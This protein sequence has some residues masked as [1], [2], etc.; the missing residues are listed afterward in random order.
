MSIYISRSNTVPDEFLEEFLGHLRSVGYSGAVNRWK[1]GST[2][3]ARPLD[4][5]SVMILLI[6]SS[7]ALISKGSYDEYLRAY[8]SRTPVYLA[9]KTKNY[10][11]Q[12][13][14]FSVDRINS[15]LINCAKVTFGVNCTDRVLKSLNI[16]P[17]TNAED[18]LA[19]NL[20]KGSDH[21]IETYLEPEEIIVLNID[22]LLLRTR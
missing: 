21:D 5:A 11:F 6:D 13:Y 22:L 4:E 2:Y 8:A 14:C 1:R 16:T 18:L 9:Y 3:S 12:F 20:F 17:V 7:A 10:G 15:N 19:E